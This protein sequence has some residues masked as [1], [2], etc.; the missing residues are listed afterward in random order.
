MRTSFIALALI[1]ALAP[2]I[3][4]QAT[5]PAD[6][7]ALD[8]RMAPASSVPAPAQKTFFVRSDLGWLAGAIAVTAG[9]S[10]FDVRISHFMLDPNQQAGSFHSIVKPFNNVSETTVSWAAVAGYGLGRLTHSETVADVSLHVGEALVISTVFGQTVRGVGGR[11]RPSTSPDDQYSFHWGQGFGHFP[12][13]AFPSLHS[14][15][16]FILASAVTEEVHERAPGAT[17][18]VG[19]VLYVAAAGPGLARMYLGQHWAS[20]VFAGAFMGTFLG[21]RVVRYAHSHKRSKLDRIFLGT[22]PDGRGHSVVTIG[23]HY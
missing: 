21:Y 8:L 13:R 19:P 12:Y 1:S 22:A 9:I 4:A 6:S 16:G 7:P 3:A 14:A 2:S 10:A 15:A 23:L 17:W 20:D 5:G 18:Y 11:A